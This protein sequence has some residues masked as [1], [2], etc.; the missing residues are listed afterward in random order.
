MIN[1]VVVD[2][3]KIHRKKLSGLIV[4]NMMNNKIEFSV[5]EFSD[6]S[7]ELLDFINNSNTSTVYILDL[8]LPNGDG[9]DIARTI[10]NERNDWI[11]PII[12]ITAHTSLYYEVYKQRLQILDFIGK[13]E[14]IE[15]NL[16]ENID[17]CIRMLNKENAYR[18]TYKSV[19]HTIPFS[20]IDYIQRDGRKTK[21]VTSDCD[22]Y[23][24]IS[25]NNIKEHLSKYFVVSSKGTLINLKNIKKIDWSKCLVYFK[26]GKSA[27]VVSKNHKKELSSC[28][29]V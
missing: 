1:F 11:S 10:R 19:E 25:I 6:Y 9:I 13:C 26:D 12:I 18:Y 4:S 23:Q 28:E 8:E 16:S 15:K 24:N 21:I 22:Y 3:N 29:M 14:N 20:N 17:I 5:N 2:D 7:D 27:F